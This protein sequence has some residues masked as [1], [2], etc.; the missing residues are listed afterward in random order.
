MTQVVQS[1]DAF[2]CWCKCSIWTMN[3]L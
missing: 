3:S 1:I 2:Q